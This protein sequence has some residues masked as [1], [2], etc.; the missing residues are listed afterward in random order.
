MNVGVTE[1]LGPVAGV[2][3]HLPLGRATESDRLKGAEEENDNTIAPALE[4]ARKASL[5][6]DFR[7]K[8]VTMVFSGNIM[9]SVS[10]LW[11]TDVSQGSSGDVTRGKGRVVSIILGSLV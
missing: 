5:L 6:R 3:L 8:K 2:T 11:N 7:R 4:N 1:C 10:K 9:N